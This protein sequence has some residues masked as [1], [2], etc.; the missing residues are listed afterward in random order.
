MITLSKKLPIAQNLERLR[1]IKRQEI[2]IYGLPIIV[3]NIESKSYCPHF[4]EYYKRCPN[5]ECLYY[6]SGLIITYKVYNVKG[7]MLSI[8]GD[9]YL[10]LS[11]GLTPAGV[12]VIVINYEDKEIFEKALIDRVPI[13]VAGREYLIDRISPDV[14]RISARVECREAGR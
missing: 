6:P 5:P 14:L 7:I 10:F 2:E 12:Y 1:R 3:K 4:D 13:E 8:A 9:E 11:A